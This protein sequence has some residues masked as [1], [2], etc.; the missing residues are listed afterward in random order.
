MIGSL[1]EEKYDTCMMFKHKLK[2]KLEKSFY[3]APKP[4]TLSF[5]DDI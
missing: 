1:P 4:T 5:Y 2:I 3:E